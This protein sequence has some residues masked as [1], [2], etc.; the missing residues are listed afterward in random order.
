MT[1]N[2]DIPL[3]QQNEYTEI[4]GQMMDLFSKTEDPANDFAKFLEALGLASGFL[5]GSVLEVEAR[6]E[7]LKAY[8]Q[9]VVDATQNCN[10]LHLIANSDEGI[11]AD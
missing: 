8:L 7:L 4:V 3:R 11:K 2:V 10:H 6:K 5:I 1:L 9:Q